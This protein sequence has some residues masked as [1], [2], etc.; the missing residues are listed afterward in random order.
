MRARQRQDVALFAAHVLVLERGVGLDRGRETGK[1]GRAAVLVAGER[2]LQRADVL[3]AG[4]MLVF[5]EVEEGAAALQRARRN[6][7]RYSLSRG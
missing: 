1:L 7:N 3:R 4:A 5:Q 2:L 6:R